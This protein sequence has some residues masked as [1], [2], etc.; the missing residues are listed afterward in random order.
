MKYVS[1]VPAIALALATLGAAAG[2]MQIQ[3]RGKLTAPPDRPLL[4]VGTDPVIQE[5]L[6]EDFRVSK[7]SADSG[8]ANPLTLTVT[9]SQKMLRPGVSLGDVSPGDAGVAS[10]LQEA[11]ATPPP[12]GDTGSEPTDP[13]ANEALAEQR[14]QESPQLQELRRAQ[15]Y[16]RGFG[17]IKE[18]S[19]YDNLPGTEIYDTAIIVH[20]R[21]SNSSD[22]MTIVAVVHPGENDRQTKELIAERIA[23]AILQ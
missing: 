22:E 6:N 2:G 10:M 18:P 15:S 14:L 20:A 16:R 12:L 5:T 19:P 23:N 13:Y 3:T 17:M 21:L 7:R 11:G 9:S 4:V 8:A 1:K